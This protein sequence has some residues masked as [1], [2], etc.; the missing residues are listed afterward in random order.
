MVLNKNITEKS[1]SYGWN[2]A[3]QL[4]REFF[5]YWH[6]QYVENFVELN[7]YYCSTGVNIDRDCAFNDRNGSLRRNRFFFFYIAQ[8]EPHLLRGWFRIRHVPE[9]WIFLNNVKINK[10]KYAILYCFVDAYLAQIS[11][12]LAPGYLTYLL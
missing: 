2:L 1:S 8:V 6:P 7:K 10:V 4:G 5:H 9:Q 12:Y 11:I 3:L